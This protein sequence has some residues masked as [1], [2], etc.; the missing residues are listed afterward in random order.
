MLGVSVV[1]LHLSTTRVLDQ[2]SDLLVRNV[3]EVLVPLAD[4]HDLGGVLLLF[5]G[6][7]LLG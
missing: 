5:S 7:R 2:L 1:G 4:G 3:L 6:M